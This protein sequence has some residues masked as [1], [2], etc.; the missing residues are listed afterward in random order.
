MSGST[1]YITPELVAAVASGYLLD[2]AGIHG[3]SHW[4]RVCEF[5]CRLA[6]ASGTDS[7]LAE[8]F[9][10]VHDCRRLDDG[11]DAEHGLRAAAEL[12]Q[13][14][15][16]LI[17]LPADDFDRL[18]YACEH[19]TEGMVSD[20]PLIGSCWDADRLDLGRLRYDIDVALLSTAAAKQ[21][22]LLTW[23]KNQSVKLVTPE[24]VRRE[25]ALL[26]QLH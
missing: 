7:Q 10:L 4:A 16:G 6:V 23:A 24:R 15:G 1:T 26:W 22:D 20:D 19:H 25:W 13:W 5:G 18:I 8:L 11:H 14:Q 2:P 21:P 3:F 9:A 12:R 17:N